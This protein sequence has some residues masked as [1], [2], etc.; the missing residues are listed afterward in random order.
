MPRKCPECKESGNTAHLP[1]CSFGPSIEDREEYLK[2]N[3]LAVVQELERKV[4][5]L[6]RRIV[7]LEMTVRSLKRKRVKEGA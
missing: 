7:Q 2:E 5:R 3:A 4:R 1:G 6:R